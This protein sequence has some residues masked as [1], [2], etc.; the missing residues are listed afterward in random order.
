MGLLGGNNESTL[1]R[2]GT[3]HAVSAQQM[4]RVLHKEQRTCQTSGPAW[5]LSMAPEPLTQG[6]LSSHTGWH[7]CPAEASAESSEQEGASS[8]GGEALR[9]REP[10]KGQGWAGTSATC[11]ACCIRS[12]NQ[13]RPTC[14]TSGPVSDT[15]ASA[16]KTHLSCP[17]NPGRGR[18]LLTTAR[19]SWRLPVPG[20][21][22]RPGPWLDHT[23]PHYCRR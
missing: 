21:T 20:F 18:L 17:R 16:E 1:G 8:T 11:P 23:R 14:L 10:G 5:R 4:N 6:P 22:L 15:E 19:G 13:A 3:W 2:P 9:G 12:V 7:S